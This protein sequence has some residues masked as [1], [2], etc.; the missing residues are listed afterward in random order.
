MSKIRWFLF[1]REVYDYPELITDLIGKLSSGSEEVLIFIP[2]NGIHDVPKQI[3]EFITEFKEKNSDITV[4]VIPFIETMENSAEKAAFQKAHKKERKDE[5]TDQDAV[6]E[7]VQ[8]SNT[9]IPDDWSRI[10]AGQGIKSCCDNLFFFYQSSNIRILLPN[11]VAHS[12]TNWRVH[13]NEVRT[14]LADKP[15]CLDK[16]GLLFSKYSPEE[17]VVKW[18]NLYQKLDEKGYG[19]WVLAQS[20]SQGSNDPA[21]CLYTNEKSKESLWAINTAGDRSCIT[22]CYTMEK[23]GKGNWIVDAFILN[24]SMQWSRY[25]GKNSGHQSRKELDFPRFLGSRSHLEIICA[26][27]ME[28]ILRRI[29]YPP[30]ERDSD[31]NP[32]VDRI[33]FSYFDSPIVS[34]VE[35]DLVITWLDHM[36]LRYISQMEGFIAV[37]S[38]STA[39]AK[40]LR[41]ASEKFANKYLIVLTDD[42]ALQPDKFESPLDTCMEKVKQKKIMTRFV[43]VRSSLEEPHQI[44]EPLCGTMEFSIACSDA[45]VRRSIE[46][47]L[48]SHTCEN[49]LKRDDKDDVNI[50]HRSSREQEDTHEMTVQHSILNAQKHYTEEADSEKFLNQEEH[51]GR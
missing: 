16:D 2:S 31:G 39:L 24:D 50:H 41:D 27:E 5:S 30:P 25:S 3:T 40:D 23:N 45:A 20:C 43:I 48:E 11:T 44:D 36:L 21:K 35:R 26:K 49:P 10:N 47:Y 37:R 7:L 9:N 29:I 46:S 32:G 14:W 18:E 38:L 42:S 6:L 8:N 13:G 28:S 22:G 19:L 17:C 15:D 1:G 33:C 12:E 34:M 4:H 51:N